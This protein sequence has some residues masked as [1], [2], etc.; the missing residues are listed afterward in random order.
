MPQAA[1]DRAASNALR[2]KFAAGLFDGRAMN[3]G[4][5]LANLNTPANRALARQVATEGTVLLK[6]DPALLPLRLGGAAPLRLAIV[7]PLAGCG[8]NSSMCD[9]TYSQCGG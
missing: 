9:A 7:G 1:L 8:D 2:A 6:T 5:D 4:S 3:N